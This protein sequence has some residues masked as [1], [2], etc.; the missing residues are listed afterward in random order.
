MAALTVG[1]RSTPLVAPRIAIVGCFSQTAAEQRTSLIAKALQHAGAEVSVTPLEPAPGGGRANSNGNLRGG[2]ERSR[3][4]SRL[5]GRARAIKDGVD[6]LAHAACTGADVIFNYSESWMYSVPIWTIARR[7]QIRLVQD[8]VEWYE[9]VCFG[10]NGLHPLL[11]DHT[12]KRKCLAARADGVTVIT[13]RLESLYAARGASTFLLP[14]LCDGLE[15]EDDTLRAVP[16]VQRDSLEIVV[17]ASGKPADGDELIRPIL[18]TARNRGVRFGV[19]LIGSR[20][21]FE[22]RRCVGEPM[23]SGDYEIVRLAG[24]SRREYLQRLARADVFLLPRRQGLS[25]EAA[26]PN[27]VPEYLASGGVLLTTGVGDL[28]RYIRNGSS[29]L[30]CDP[31]DVSGFASA[32]CWVASHRGAATEIGENG[33]RVA[34]SQFDYRVHA[35][36]LLR[37]VLGRP[38]RTETHA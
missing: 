29:G 4:R 35:E 6:S 11:L 5:I 25:S 15:F 1:G 18:E 34:L 31:D 27:R 26:F 33:R 10:G 20:D 13:S 12:R 19:T 24:L 30:V 9:P 7:H 21:L 37:F 28:P 22:G 23:E 36:A 17:V 16:R 14:G 32:L 3:L 8:C 2:R 38:Q